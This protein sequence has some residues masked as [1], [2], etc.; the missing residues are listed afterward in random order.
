MM[1]PRN[2]S[3]ES[4][5][6]RFTLD[7]LTILLSGCFGV[8]HNLAATFVNCRRWPI[9]L[10]SRGFA[11]ALERRTFADTPHHH[12]ALLRRRDR[13]Q[14][15]ADSV[16]RNGVE[17]TEVGERP[18]VVAPRIVRQGYDSRRAVTRAA[19]RIE[20]DVPVARTRCQNEKIDPP[21][22]PDSLVILRGR[23]GI[24]KPD[25]SIRQSTFCRQMLVPLFDDQRTREM[26]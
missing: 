8:A 12:R 5:R 21:C 20:R 17:R 18:Q 19:G 10:V 1:T 4:M 3:T 22:R 13:R 11:H 7:A 24:R 25:G 14:A 2:K 6:L 26:M 15:D 9:R 23:A 16:A